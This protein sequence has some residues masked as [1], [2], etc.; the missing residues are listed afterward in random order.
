MGGY[1]YPIDLILLDLL[2]FD[3]ILGMDWLSTCY[4]SVNYRQ[5]SFIFEYP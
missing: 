2:E 1:T 3:V 5:K 4:A